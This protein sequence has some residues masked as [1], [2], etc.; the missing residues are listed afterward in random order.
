M[1]IN[2]YH[3]YFSMLSSHVE[4]KE[5]QQLN[6]HEPDDTDNAP[7]MDEN[8]KLV[9]VQEHNKLFPKTMNTA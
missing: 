4:V 1:S 6:L 7:A 2:K 8:K 9:A 5:P 3:T